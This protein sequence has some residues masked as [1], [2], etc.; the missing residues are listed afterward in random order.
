MRRDFQLSE[1]DTQCL[2][3]QGVPWDAI[4]EN[5]VKWIVLRGYLLPAGYNH[6]TADAAIRIPPSYP[7]G[8]LDMVYFHP[9]LALA[10]KR[11]IAKLTPHVLEGK[12]Y[13]QWSRHYDW[14][15]GLHNLCTHLLL[16]K[17]WLEREVRRAA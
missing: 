17:T 5:N 11:A 14:Q 3:A 15:P 10:T 12:Q 7:D 6:S 9:A 2:E 13:Q 16:I 1:E 8:G 4:I